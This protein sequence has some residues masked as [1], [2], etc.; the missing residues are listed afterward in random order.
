MFSSDIAI[1]NKDNHAQPADGENT[2]TP[3]K[4]ALLSTLQNQIRTIEAVPV[5]L[6]DIHTQ[7]GTNTPQNTHT[8]PEQSPHLAASWCH[9]AWARRPCDMAA[10]TALLLA[11]IPAN[12]KPI[13]WI[14]DATMLREYG[15][16]YA[17]GLAAFATA[18]ERLILVRTKGRADALWAIEEGLKS[19]IVA[20]V[21]GEISGMELTE[22]RRLSLAAKESGLQC[23]LLLRSENAPPSTSFS[24]WRLTS[25]PSSTHTFHAKLPGY[26]RL[27]AELVK[28][29]GGQPPHT[30]LLEWSHA[31]NRFAVVAPV[32]DGALSPRPPRPH[33]RAR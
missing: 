18:P 26:T 15:M 8:A 11:N 19:G 6:A 9:E 31:T 3:S 10:N 24:R 27:K 1:T 25:A 5:S 12:N 22:S 30:Q 4:K 2:R 16:P 28:H 13:L 14:S 23:L 20:A 29:R 32:A 33:A 7:I 21:V 17:P